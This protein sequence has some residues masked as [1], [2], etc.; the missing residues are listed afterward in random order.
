MSVELDAYSA[1]HGAVL[2][3]DEGY[4]VKITRD[5]DGV[6]V[7]A[8][9]AGLR[10]LARHLLTLANIQVPAGHHIHF[11]PSLELEDDSDPLVLEKLE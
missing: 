1:G 4:K 10:S 8:N 2:T 7:A 3:W 5:S 11:E 9:A 6:V